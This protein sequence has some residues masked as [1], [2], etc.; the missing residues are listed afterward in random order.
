M[1]A[2]EDGETLLITHVG[3]RHEGLYICRGSNWAGV[4]QAE[5]Q[6]SV[7]GEYS[8]WGKSCYPS[9][10]SGRVWLAKGRVFLAL[11]LGRCSVARLI[12]WDLALCQQG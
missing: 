7:Q 2:S 10:V 4:A 3:L 9:H 6:V 8:I 1:V 5:V 12:H 11:L